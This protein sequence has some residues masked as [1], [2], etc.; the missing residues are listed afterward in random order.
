MREVHT[1]SK[2]EVS[3]AAG[4]CYALRRDGCA[5]PLHLRRL[6]LASEKR[7]RSEKGIRKQRLSKS[8]SQ[9]STSV[10]TIF[11]S[12]LKSILDYS[13]VAPTKGQSL[14][15]LRHLVRFLSP[16][17]SA[18]SSISS[19]DRLHLADGLGVHRVSSKQSRL[20]AE[21]VEPQLQRSFVGR[22][23]LRDIAFGATAA[24]LTAHYI[25]S[26]LG[27]DAEEV[28]TNLQRSAKVVDELL[29]KWSL[30]GG[31]MAS[32]DHAES[33]RSEARAI[34]RARA[35]AVAAASVAKTQNLPTAAALHLQFDWMRA[36]AW[37]RGTP[38]DAE[39]HSHLCELIAKG[40]RLGDPAAESLPLPALPLSA[41]QS[42]TA[43][44]LDTGIGD[45]S[46]EAG[47]SRTGSWASS[48]AS[49]LGSVDEENTG[50][51][52]AEVA[53]LFRNL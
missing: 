30:S 43:A 47:S 52:A 8:A 31:T 4:E 36:A 37:P 51:D 12:T 23:G 42:C 11:G 18:V 9:L 20:F 32:G 45:D 26:A 28:A 16:A 38:C 41:L 1:S 33:L 5:A 22:N 29:G 34:R 14:Q 46:S 25:M 6:I 27:A 49:S 10:G 7:T 2:G 48:A 19:Q 50:T 3:R 17:S 13:G 39:G 15:A 21:S 24:V 44:W 53:L 35:A 40:Q